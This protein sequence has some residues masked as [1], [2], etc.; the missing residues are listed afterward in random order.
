MCCALAEYEKGELPAPLLEPAIKR[1]R[2]IVREFKAEGGYEFEAE[3]APE[4]FLQQEIK[5]LLEDLNEALSG[6]ALPEPRLTKEVMNAIFD[7]RFKKD[8]SELEPQFTERNFNSG[9]LMPTWVNGYTRGFKALRDEL[10]APVESVPSEK[11]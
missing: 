10:L 1:I 8:L 7:E 2:E 11:E 4:A 9:I 3:T 5:T 6:V